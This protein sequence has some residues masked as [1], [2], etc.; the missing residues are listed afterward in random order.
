MLRAQD[1]SD[2]ALGALCEAYRQPL[3][4]W[5][6]IRDYAPEDARTWFRVSLPTCSS[7]EFLANIGREKGKFRTFI[8]K[9]FQHYLSDQRDKLWPAN[10]VGAGRSNR[11]TRRARRAAGSMIHPATQRRTSNTTELAPGR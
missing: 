11:L 10:G 3:V 4:T 6:R 5:L 9:C 7:R 1:N 8:L 2:A